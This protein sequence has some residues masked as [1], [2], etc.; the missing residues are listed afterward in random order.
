MLSCSYNPPVRTTFGLA[1]TIVAAAAA[2]A[3]AQSPPPGGTAIE[4]EAMRHFQAIL[5][6]DTSNPPGNESQVVEYLDGVLKQAGIETKI[7]GRDPKRSNLVARLKGNGS[8]RPLLIMGHTDVVTVDPAKWQ[9][10]PFSATREGGYV[11]G[12]GTLDDKP[13]VAAGL[14]TMLQLKRM[15][16]PL[17]RDVIFLAEAS[18]EG[19]GP[20][21]INYMV[22][23]QWKEIEAEYCIAEGGG[24]ER[25]GGKVRFAEVSASEKIPHT[26]RIVARGVAGHGSVPLQSNAI[27]HLSQAI[28]KIA[29]W[30]TPMRLNETTRTYFEGLAGISPPEDAARY[31]AVVEGRD[32]EAAQDHFAA[33]AP[34]LYSLLRT[35]IS[36]NIVKGGYLRNV[37]PS[38][39]EATLDIRALPDEDMPAFLDR[40][41]AVIGDP[42]IEVLSG[43]SGSVRPGAP[44][45]RLDTEAFKVIEAV[46]RRIYGVA[47][48]PTMLTGATDMAQVRARGVQCYGIGPMTDTEDVLKGFAAHSDQE[49]ILEDAF[50]KFDRAHWEIVRELAKNGA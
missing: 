32:V 15:N 17:D 3:G 24:V 41:R 45:S 1:G 23:E 26:I 28:A 7:V 33:K 40:L 9:H 2:L 14:M 6:L 22:A 35:S 21:G 48:L 36:P 5:R 12:R 46:N 16:V 44:P 13:D 19:N 10:P 47:T 4:D 8:K 20:F 30:R 18:E 39:A 49:R 29:A 11:Y 31:R 42:A 27:V 25:E 43:Q 37:I 38:E 50:H 34:Q